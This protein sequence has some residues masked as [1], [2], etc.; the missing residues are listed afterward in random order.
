MTCHLNGAQRA[1]HQATV[2][3]KDHLTRG[4]GDGRIM[5]GGTRSREAGG[6]RLQANRRGHQ[7]M[8]RIDQFLTAVGGAYWRAANGR[9]LRGLE[10]SRNTAGARVPENHLRPG[11]GLDEMRLRLWQ[12]EARIAGWIAVEHVAGKRR[13]RW[14]LTRRQRP[15][16]SPARR[17]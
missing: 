14:D 9:R 15:W 3:P 12:F 10:R 8:G 4:G 1:K 13:G 5:K 16:H 6:E 2:T 17:N 11:E 7:F